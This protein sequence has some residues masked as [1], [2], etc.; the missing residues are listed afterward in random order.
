M[1]TWK[2][3]VATVLIGAGIGVG[4]AGVAAAR[5]ITQVGGGT[6]YHGLTP[7]YVYSDYFHSTRCH[8]STAV[9]TY[10]VRSATMGPGYT[11]KASAPRAGWGNES[12]WRVC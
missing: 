2:K 12:Y 7:S 4:A 1:N 9:G 8:G 11:S 5:E 3:A 6:W 10:T